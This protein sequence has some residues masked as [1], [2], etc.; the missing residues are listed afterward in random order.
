M[1]EFMMITLGIA[2][3]S[4]LIA[5]LLSYFILSTSVLDQQRIQSRRYRQGTFRRRVPLIAFNLFCLFS[6]TYVGVYFG[7]TLFYWELEP[8]GWSS[9]W[10]ISQLAIFVLIDDAYFYFFHR[11]L[12]ENPWLYRHIHKTHHHAFAPFPLEYIYV[13]PLEWMMG[14]GGIPLA[15]GVIYLCQ[16]GV[17]VWAFWTFAL[18]RN[19]HEVEIHSGLQSGWRGRLP[20]YGT[21]EHHDRHHLKNSKGNYGSAFTFWDWVFGTLLDEP[22]SL[23]D[24]LVQQE[25]VIS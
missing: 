6:I 13:H 10:V 22:K 16:G 17:S 15:I 14:A 18:W 21:T 12:H 24:D 23:S 3:V 11:A 19:L 2:V 8:L 20:L 9:L 1:S 7:E 5:G 25:D 4:N